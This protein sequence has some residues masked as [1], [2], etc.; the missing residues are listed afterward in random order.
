MPI[1]HEDYHW[2]LTPETGP[3][4]PGQ[5]DELADQEPVH[6][7]QPKLPRAGTALL[8]FLAFFGTQFLGFLLV[9]FV[10]GLYAGVSGI[11][12][13][14]TRQWLGPIILYSMLPVF[15]VSGLPV[16]A[17]TR[18]KAA[19][20]IRDGSPSGVGWLPSTP[21]TL[22]GALLLGALFAFGCLFLYGTVF[23]D[24]RPDAGSSIAEMANTGTLARL[25]LGVMV[26]VVAPLIE[27]T[28]FRGVML[29]G[30]TRSFGLPLSIFI[31]TSLFVAGHIAE[32]MRY[33]PGT[34]GIAGLALL[35]MWLRLKTKSVFPAMALHA[36]YNGLLVTL[37][38]LAPL[39]QN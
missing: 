30:L 20:A 3:T 4:E 19:D 11:P 6:A 16:M 35:A 22:L 39:L 9:G 36:G 21:L 17:I 7:P 2:P 25:L 15:L 38:F 1:E 32:L 34:I 29:A 18:S 31:C 28:I 26:I 5:G 24:V 27:E 8:V 10:A 33:P 13:E 37:M 14:E 23:T 12:K